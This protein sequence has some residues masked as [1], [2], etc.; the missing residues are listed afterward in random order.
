MHSGSDPQRWLEEIRTTLGRPP[1]RVGT[2]WLFGRWASPR[3]PWLIDDPLD[4]LFRERSRMLREGQVVWGMVL[5]ASVTTHGPGPRVPRSAVGWLLFP[6][7]PEAIVDPQWLSDTAAQMHAVWESRHL[8]QDLH[9][10]MVHVLGQ[11]ARAFGRLV[12]RTVAFE[13]QLALTTTVL[14]ARHLPRR[15]IEFIDGPLPE[16]I[17]PVVVARD[18]PQVAMVVPCGHWPRELRG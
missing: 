4:L 3:P 15:R 11:D 6:T 12:P 9:D 2:A 5:N 1:R 7:D 16:G 8:S 17:V 10:I 14:Y 18:A 13:H